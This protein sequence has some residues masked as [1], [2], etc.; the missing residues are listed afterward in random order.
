MPSTATMNQQLLTNNPAAP[1]AATVTPAPPTYPAYPTNG[2]P[3]TT[4]RPKVG[5]WWGEPKYNGWAALVHT[6][7]GAMFNHDL[8]RSTIEAEFDEA[9]SQLR[10]LPFEWL[11]CEALERRHNI[12][13]GSLIVLDLVVGFATYEQRRTW[14]EEKL[15]T[16][17]HPDLIQNNRAY[18][19]PN[20]HQPD[21]TKELEI[22]AMLQRQNEDTG[23]EF[24]E[25]FVMK[26]AG[27]LYPIQL[28]TPKE[29]ARTW[30]K[31][32]W[33]F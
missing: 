5:W 32:R 4:A 1:A 17:P 12:G 15:L 8:Q 18:V 22:W 2:G 3:L 14:L 11:H 29:K 20:F 7:T 33:S 26:K 28:R 30:V 23:C 19:T 6:P 21:R 24:Y 13:R 25:G 16:A 9:L 31:H 27:S 10:L